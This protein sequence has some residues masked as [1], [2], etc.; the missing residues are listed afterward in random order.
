MYY[1]GPD[2]EPA[3]PSNSHW[4]CQSSC[5]AHAE[6]EVFTFKSDHCHLKKASLQTEAYATR[7]NLAISGPANGCIDALD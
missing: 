5:A 7:L 3:L 2:L 1:S 6:C 4:D